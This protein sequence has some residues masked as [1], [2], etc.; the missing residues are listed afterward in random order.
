MATSE[1]TGNG[2]SS[3][4]GPSQLNEHGNLCMGI[5]VVFLALSIVVPSYCRSLQNIV[6]H[7]PGRTGQNINTIQI[8]KSWGLQ[9]VAHCLVD[10]FTDVVICLN[11]W[12]YTG[13]EYERHE[14]NETD[15][16]AL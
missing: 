9:P 10:S 12:A 5:Q 6:K 15:R 1:E 13:G 8:H 16:Q 4:M 7:N 2:D 11:T 14:L 3:T